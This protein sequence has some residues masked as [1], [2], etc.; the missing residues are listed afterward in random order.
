[1]TKILSN[2]GSF[3]I[4]I[5]ATVLLIKSEI[6]FAL[7]AIITLLAILTVGMNDVAS[8]LEESE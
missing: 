2:L 5:G 6:D 4:W 3:L 8:K 1:M 7:Y